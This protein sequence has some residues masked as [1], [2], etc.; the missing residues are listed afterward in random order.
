M[1]FSNTSLCNHEAMPVRAERTNR[2]QNHPLHAKARLITSSKSPFSKPS[3]IHLPIRQKRPAIS[4][5]LIIFFQSCFKSADCNTMQFH[6]QIISFC[7]RPPT[8]QSYTNLRKYRIGN[9]L[10]YK[11]F[12]Q[13]PFRRNETPKEKIES[14]IHFSKTPIRCKGSMFVV[15]LSVSSWYSISKARCLAGVFSSSFHGLAYPSSGLAAMGS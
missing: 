10:S 5:L 14:P 6:L 4:S 7:C 9:I 15:V 11:A 2:S 8:I 12:E 3:S 13:T 1:K